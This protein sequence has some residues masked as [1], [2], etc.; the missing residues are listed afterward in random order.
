M[1]ELIAFQNTAAHCG[2]QDGYFRW[3]CKCGNGPESIRPPP[4][5]VLFQREALDASMETR[6]RTNATHQHEV[7]LKDHTHCRLGV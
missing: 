4:K 1:I 6:I 3:H 7:E 2:L 5:R